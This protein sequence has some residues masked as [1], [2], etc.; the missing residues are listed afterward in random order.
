LSVVSASACGQGEA[1]D[2]LV[3][4]HGGRIVRIEIKA[5]TTRPLF[6]HLQ[7]ADWIRGETD[8][9]GALVE[10]DPAASGH[11]TAALRDAVDGAYVREH[12]WG[13]SAL[14]AAD[15]AGLTSSAVRRR[16]GVLTPADLT[17]FVA[18]KYV[19]HTT[20]QGLR[21]YRLADVP[22][23]TSGL[24]GR[25]SY[26]LIGP[27]SGSL[28]TVRTRGDG[29]TP[30][31]GGIHLTYYLGQN[32]RPDHGGHH[33]HEAFFAGAAPALTVRPRRSP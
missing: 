15:V 28:L 17:S 21:M 29:Q 24:A 7:N 18:S 23:L 1:A 10:T 5:Q 22:N 30:R 20:Q 12:G 33:M 16:L 14:W 13:L 9:L 31:R 19:V 25:V 2:V 27:R 3:E 6:K 32:N 26:A 8:F 4:C 11:L